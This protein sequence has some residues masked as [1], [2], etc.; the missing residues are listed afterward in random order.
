MS[1]SLEGFQSLEDGLL[2]EEE[3]DRDSIRNLISIYKG[4]ISSL[5][6][7]TTKRF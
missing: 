5:S 4:F 1:F 2:V 7:T 6:E 3:Y